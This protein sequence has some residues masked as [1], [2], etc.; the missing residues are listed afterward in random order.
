MPNVNC[1]VRSSPRLCRT[2]N[3]CEPCERSA[4]ELLVPEEIAGGLESHVAEFENAAAEVAANSK[5]EQ[6]FRLVGAGSVAPGQAHLA[7]VAKEE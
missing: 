7:L 2:Q 6:A 1:G 3:R 5:I 4:P